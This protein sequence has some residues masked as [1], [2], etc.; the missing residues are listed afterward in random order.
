MNVELQSY[1][2]HNEKGDSILKLEMVNIDCASWLSFNCAIEIE[3]E[4]HPLMKIAI[5]KLNSSDTTPEDELIIIQD[6]LSNVTTIQGIQNCKMYH[7]TDLEAQK[8]EQIYNDHLLD[9]AMKN[10]SKPFTPFI[11]GK[12]SFYY[13]RFVSILPTCFIFLSETNREFFEAT[14]TGQT[15]LEEQYVHNYSKEASFYTIDVT[16]AEEIYKFFIMKTPDILLF[17]YVKRK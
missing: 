1:F 16:H 9:F 2:T 7:H 17:F 5:E 8:R 6:I 4:K 13:E 15:L 12:D 14:I 11:A 10:N 3:F